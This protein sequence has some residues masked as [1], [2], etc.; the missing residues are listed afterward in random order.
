MVRF[1]EKGGAMLCLFI[2]DQVRKNITNIK[3]WH[4][5]LLFTITALLDQWIRCCTASTEL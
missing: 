2:L 1:G 5:P 4:L 3:T